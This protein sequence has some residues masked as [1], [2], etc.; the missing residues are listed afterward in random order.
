MSTSK[1]S[2][3]EIGITF[4]ASLALLPLQWLVTGWYAST[5]WAWFIA[6]TFGIAPL[7]GIQSVGVA[8][9]IAAFAPS[10]L[11]MK[12]D[13][14]HEGFALIVVGISHIVGQI[15]ALGFAWLFHSLA[16]G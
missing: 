6:P 2:G 9:A 16:F 14:S 3:V 4:V 5:V 15:L 11:P 13:E 12:G 8:I 1:T 10:R 7:T